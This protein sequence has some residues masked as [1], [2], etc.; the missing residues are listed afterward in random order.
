MI[1][2]NTD[3]IL[4]VMILA[5]ILGSCRENGCSFAYNLGESSSRFLG[6]HGSHSAFRLSFSLYVPCWMVLSTSSSAC[7][8]YTNKYHNFESGTVLVCQKGPGVSFPFW[9]H[10]VQRCSDALLGLE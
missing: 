7:I 2:A 6:F 9:A 1:L 4:G 3:C 10:Y 5:A 8:H